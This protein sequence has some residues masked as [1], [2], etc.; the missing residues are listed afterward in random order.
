MRIAA[1]KHR[2]RRLTAPAGKKVRPTLARAREALFDILAHK[3]LSGTGAP[4]L[5]GARVLEA[6]S[7]SGAFAFEALSRGAAGAILMDTEPAALDA[8]RRNAANLSEGARVTVL[9]MDATKPGPAQS[10][11]S[12][13]FLDPPYGSG[14][15]APALAALAAKGWLADGA[16]CV[17]EV[18]A[19]EPF[20]PPAGFTALDVRRYGAA[21]FVFVR[22]Q[23]GKDSPPRHKATKD[24]PK[25]PN[26]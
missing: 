15:A 1:G 12:L 18:A 11:A 5:A 10:A 6:F 22:W 17:I 8:A 4:V 2:G 24:P 26:A 13:V 19:K 3:R 21:R 9:K 20:D 14:L 23:S 16:L 7:G 25:A